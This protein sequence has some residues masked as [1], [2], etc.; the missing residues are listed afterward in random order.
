MARRRNHF[1]FT[2]KKHSKKGILALGIA[3]VMLMIYAAILIY[4]YQSREELSVYFGSVGI[5]ALLGAGT[6]LVL[7]LQSL[8]EENSF[9]F[10]PRLAAFVSFLAFM[11]WGGTYLLGFL[12]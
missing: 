8:G 10:F 9:H 4:S 3:L 12:L 5:F 11:G 1:K 7:A 2:Q 6:A